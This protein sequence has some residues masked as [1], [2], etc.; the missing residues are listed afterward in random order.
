MIS[1]EKNFEPGTRNKAEPGTRNKKQETKQKLE[2][3]RKLG[4][5]NLSVSLCNPK[6]G[7]RNSEQI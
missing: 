1:D 4:I 2:G 7:T 6:H 5:K 3:R